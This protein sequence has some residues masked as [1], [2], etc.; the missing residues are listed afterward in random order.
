MP[1]SKIRSH[2]PGSNKYVNNQTN[3]KQLLKKYVTFEYVKCLVFDPAALPVVTIFILLAELVLNVLV[4]WRV[5]YTEIDWIA[6]MQQCE[7]FLNGTLNYALLKGDTGPLVYPAAFVYIYT[8]LYYITSHGQNI[9]LAQYI[10][11]CIYLV[12]MWLVLRLYTKSRKVPPYVLVISAFTSYRIH[13]IYVLRLF[14]DPIAILFLYAALNLFLDRHWTLGSTFF[15]LAVGVKMNI[16]LFAPALLLFYLANLGYFKTFLQLAV[17]GCLQILL[18]APFLITYPMQYIKGSFNFGRIFEHKWT[19]NYRFLSRDLF[20]DK[21]FHTSLLVAH[22][23]LL[24]LFAKPVYTF[25]KNYVRL[26]ALQDQL[27][28]QIQRKNLEIKGIHSKGAKK[29][30]KIKEPKPLEKEEELTPDQQAFLNSFEKGLQKTTG[31]K[32]PPQ[33]QDLILENEHKVSIHFERC[34]QLAILPFF[35]CNFI[36]LVCARSLHYQFYVWYFHS[37][38]YLTWSTDYS[39]GIRF[40]LLGLIELCW[41]TYPS[42]DISSGLLH[43]CHFVLLF[44]VGKNLFKTTVQSAAIRSMQDQEGNGTI[45]AKLK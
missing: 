4:I 32:K 43:V 22:L 3:I 44:G 34:T 30:N 20:E 21:I 28:P 26:R 38:P 14:N 16:L 29:H 15:S 18:G 12:Q 23:L 31:L 39:L 2:P 17:C 36:G 1:P 42:T 7:G 9:R 13:S 19:V 10:F 35:L 33:N 25:F 8:G 27:Q 5:P 6:Y 41:N 24:A 40:L 37:L 45:K 11:V